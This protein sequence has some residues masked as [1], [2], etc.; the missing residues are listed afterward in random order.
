MFLK[1]IGGY[2]GTEGK[3]MDG[4]CRGDPTGAAKMR[5]IRDTAGD[6]F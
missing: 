5:N 2:N 1:I 6:T 3:E 4:K